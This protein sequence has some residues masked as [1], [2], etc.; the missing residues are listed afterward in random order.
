[1][2]NKNHPDFPKYKAECDAVHDEWVK[3]EDALEEK[4][5]ANNVNSGKDNPESTKIF[6]EF[7]KKFKEIQKKY[8]YLFE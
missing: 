4:M 7:S 6:R 5:R 3:K 1:M 8:Y 2:V